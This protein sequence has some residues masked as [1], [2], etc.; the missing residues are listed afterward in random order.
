[1][2]SQRAR[3]PARNT[4]RSSVV[5]EERIAVGDPECPVVVWLGSDK[6]GR[7]DAAHDYAGETA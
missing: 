1:M 6:H 4:G 5:L 2:R 3:R 7:L